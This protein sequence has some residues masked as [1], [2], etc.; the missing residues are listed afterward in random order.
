MN[1]YRVYQQRHPKLVDK[2][3]PTL[4]WESNLVTVGTIQAESGMAAIRAAKYVFPTFRVAAK[5]TLAA[6]PV[7]ELVEYW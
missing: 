1:T 4:G 3:Y 6:F 7:V 5:N 2:D